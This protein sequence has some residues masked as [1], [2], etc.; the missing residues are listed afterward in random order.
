VTA[1]GL[2]GRLLHDLRR[3]AIRNMER[4][5]LSRSVAMQLTGHLTESVYRRYAITSSADLQE[6]VRKLNAVRRLSAAG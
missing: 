4:S 6:G 3:S 5:G 2:P 1:V